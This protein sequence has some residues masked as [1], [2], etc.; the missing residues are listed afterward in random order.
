MH[1]IQKLTATTSLSAMAL[2][3]AAAPAV[4]QIDLPRVSQAATITQVVGTTKIEIAYSRPGVKGRA[5]WGGLVPYNEVWRTGAN[6]ATT[7]SF[8]DPVSVGGTMLPAGKYSLATIPT[9]EEWT[10]IFSKQHDLWGMYEYK[11]EM[12]A[13]RIKVKPQSAELTEW[14]AFSFP[15]VAADSAEIALTWEKVRVA[16]TVTVDSTGLTISKARAAVAAAAA[17]DF[18]TPYRAANYCLQNDVNVDEAV[19]W[20]DKSI[21]I[22]ATYGNLGAKARYLA[23]KGDVKGAIATAGKAIEA[24]KASDPKVD[25]SA[26]EKLVTE[27]KQLPR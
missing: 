15:S 26:L 11:P 19:K 14:M 21:G 6:E 1:A 7:I 5:I 16:F 3:L 22:K 13:L 24:G 25:T 27:W 8:S 20:L 17:D 10:V 2:V 4:A 18:Q 9:A 12:D 23:K